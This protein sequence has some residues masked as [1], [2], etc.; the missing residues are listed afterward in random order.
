MGPSIASLNDDFLQP[1]APYS[2][3]MR[4]ERAL[5]MTRRANLLM[6]S[7][8]IKGVWPV[9]QRL[10]PFLSEPNGLLNKFGCFRGIA[11]IGVIRAAVLLGKQFI[12]D[13]RNP[14]GRIRMLKAGTEYQGFGGQNRQRFLIALNGSSYIPA[15]QSNPEFM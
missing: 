7:V 11:Q 4:D 6:E 8:K 5:A 10:M 14:L 12:R 3:S 1:F 2:Q 13:P 15:K 9:W